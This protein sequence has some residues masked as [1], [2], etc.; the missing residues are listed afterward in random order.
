MKTPF[1]ILMT[2]AFLFSCG[3]ETPKEN[4]VTKNK[5]I[6]KPEDTTKVKTT[7]TVETTN[8]TPVS[9][10]NDSLD[11]MAKMIAGINK[12]SSAKVLGNVFSKKSFVDFS[13]SFEKKWKQYDTSRLVHLES[14]RATELSKTVGT[15]K[16]LFYPFSGP[17]FLY[18]NAF[19]P[20]ADKY[21]LMGLEPVGTRPVLDEEPEERDSLNKYFN[22][23]NT[24]LNTILRCSFFRTASMKADLRNQEL[25][26][27]LHLILLFMSR[28]GHSICAMN[29][30]NIDTAG[31][32]RYI[33]SFPELQKKPLNNKGIEIRFTTK[34][35]KEK[36]MYYFSLNLDNGGLKTNKN[37]RNYF[38]KMGE[39]NTYL[40]G[41]SYLMHESYFSSIRNTIFE[42]SQ[43]IIQDD[44]GI[45]FRYFS[46]S[47]YAW[48]YTFY[49]KYT[50]PISL[51]SYAYQKDLDSLWKTQGSKNIGFG[52][53]YNFHDKNSNLM[54]A[55]RGAF[56]PAKKKAEPVKEVKEK[57]ITKETKEDFIPKK[58][59][60]IKKKSPVKESK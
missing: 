27:T 35:G 3:T 56:D 20:D 28:T 8:N 29:P 54:V 43:Y 34:E 48:D 50:R 13:S 18:A 30:V 40:K 17:D 57:T 55:K 5:E 44:S 19:F 21:I 14:F 49:G 24:S 41:A 37:L 6:I 15:T 22:K 9:C 60:S 26:G 31:N 4:P 2:A 12:G 47:G 23:I 42:H 25:D 58:A 32:I 36:L 16:T 38:S 59:G 10:T 51:F 53:G 52:I 11:E 46:N 1:F 33:K 45:A 7:E 39:V